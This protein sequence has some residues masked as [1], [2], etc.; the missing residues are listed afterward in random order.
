MNEKIT[1]IAGKTGLKR[2]QII[3]ALVGKPIFY[4]VYMM[5]DLGPTV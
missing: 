1:D 3:A 2:W 5:S 4:V